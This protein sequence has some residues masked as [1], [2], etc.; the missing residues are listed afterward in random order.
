MRAFDDFKNKQKTVWSNVFWYV[1][2]SIFWKCIQYT[3]H[4]D[5]TQ[6]LKKFPLNKINGI[7]N[8]HFLLSRIPTHHNFIFNLRFLN[9]LK[10]KV[11][12]SKTVC[13]IFH[14]WF[15]FVF[16]KVYSIVQQNAWTLLRLKNVIIPFKTK[17]IES[18]T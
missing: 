1:K 17:I 5:K 13:G 6:M 10:H 4:W 12:L 9:E 15:H 16:I 11:H 14:F 2:V 8:A 18:Q 7:K 3:I